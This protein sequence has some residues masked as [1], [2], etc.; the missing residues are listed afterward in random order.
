MFLALFPLQLALFPGEHVPLHIFEPRYKQLIAECRDEGIHFGIPAF[1]NGNVSVYGTEVELVR[2]L[3]TYDSGEMDIVVR[4][5]RVFKIIKFHQNVPD[6][7]YSGANIAFPEDDPES[8]ADVEKE[9]SDRFMELMRQLDKKS[10]ALSRT[11]PALS[12]RVGAEAGLSLEQRVHLLSVL[13]EAERQRY[14]LD[15]VNRVIR[16]VR[17]QKSGPGRVSSNG[18]TRTNGRAKKS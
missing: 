3:Q 16:T 5:V 4:G 14:V 12:Y 10:D 9:L 2:I 17:E 11:S 7:L 18:H 13:R 15:H 6:K 8:D 1:V